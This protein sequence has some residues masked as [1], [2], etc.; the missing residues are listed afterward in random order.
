MN[1]IKLNRTDISEMVKRA[2]HSILSESVEEVM[3]SA[4]AEKE[5]VIQELV[6]YVEKE[7]EKIKATGQKPVST[8]T[9]SAKD[10]SGSGVI[11]S[12]VILAPDDLT[13]KLGLADRFDINIGI[14]DYQ[15]P[16]NLLKLFGYQQRGTEGTTYHGTDPQTGD[17]YGKFSKPT[18]K[19]EHS[20]IDLEVPAI[21]G[22]LQTNGLYSTLYHELNHN[23]TALSIKREKDGKKDKNGNPIDV[24]RLNPVT[25]SQR[26]SESPHFTVQRA[27]HPD[28]MIDFLTSLQY[29]PD[30]ENFRLLNFLFYAVWET[31]ERNARAEEMYGSLQ[32]LNATR[33][34]F[35]DIYP[36]TTLY[37][38]LK[39]YNEI[40]D[41]LRNVSSSSNIWLHA[42]NV[43]NMKS[44][45]SR[46]RKSPKSF[47]LNVKE[48]FIKHTEE[49]LDKMYRKGMKVAELYFQRKEDKERA[50]ADK[51][52]GGLGRLGQ[53]IDND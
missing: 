5:D 46:H 42:A 13:K 27:L 44:K 33:E 17:F 11:N 51:P 4:M 40:L 9:F 50:N 3:G 30:K 38:N 36:Q 16:K 48:R 47:G 49:L 29:G 14:N 41:K 23:S 18:L 53:M 43:M 15:A 37:N 21:N 24:D 25:T 32:G 1:V 8:G 7:W 31:T 45:D 6:E 19:I 28:P 35:W 39:Q 12:Y 26:A 52:G 20:R 34:N 22:E 10:G 2:V